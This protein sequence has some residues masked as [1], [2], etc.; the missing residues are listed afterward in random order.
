MRYTISGRGKNNQTPVGVFLARSFGHIPHPEIDSLFGFAEY[1]PLYGGRIF[2]QPEFSPR[3]VEELYQL[4][5][6]LRLPLTNHYVDKEEY[7]Q[8]RQLLEKYHRPGN[9]AIVTNDNL[10][11]W[12]RRDFP[13]YRIEAS[14]IKNVKSY[15]RIEAAFE[16]YD[17]VV[18]PMELNE[19]E[20]F[21]A[22]APK[23]ER[24]TLFANAGCALTCPSKICYVSISKLNKGR[25]GQFKCSQTVKERELRGM[26]DFDLDRLQAL[27]YSRFKLLRA[28]PDGLTGR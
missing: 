10:A 2:G 18:L 12:I 7:L 3:D 13:E 19:N 22:G 16:L 28:R 1:T 21:L 24:I 4:G 20:A 8:S 15:A 11:R 26:V 27:G 9:A 17:T 5:I 14:V 23:K 6:A 25:G